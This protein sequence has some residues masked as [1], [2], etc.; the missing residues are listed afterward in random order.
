MNEI[1]PKFTNIH[2]AA[3]TGKTT[4][5]QK[6]K[7]AGNPAFDTLLNE[8]LGKPASKTM[9]SQGLTLPE[10]SGTL[11][12]QQLNLTPD[13]TRFIE[14]LTSSLGLLE[15]YASWLSDPEKSLKETRTLLD[16][17]IAQTDSIDASAPSLANHNPELADILLR[18]KTTLQVEQIKFDRGDYL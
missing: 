8:Q 16:R 14:K 9:E 18:F 13:N 2:P 11:S 15:S 7:S 17:I 12:T 6:N 3:T 1:D 10:L 5:T 4:D